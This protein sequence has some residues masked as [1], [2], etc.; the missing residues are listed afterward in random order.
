MIYLWD[1][2]HVDRDYEFCI[3]LQDYHKLKPVARK[4]GTI[5]FIKKKCGL[6]FWLRRNR[7]RKGYFLGVL[8]FCMVIYI[9]SL[10]IWDIN[11]LGGH[12]YTPEAMVKF[13]KNNQIYAGLQK[14]QIDCQD[15]E[16]LIRGTFKDIG[17]V[18]AEIKGTRLIIKITETN[19]P[20][21]AVTATE[22]CHI[23][24]AKDCIISEIITRT[25]TPL[26]KEGSV[27]KKGDILVSG[28][29]DIVGDNAEVVEK[30]AVIA[31]ADIIGKTFYNYEDSFS[32]NYIEKQYTGEEKTGYNLSVFLKKFNLYKPRIPYT[33]YDIIVNESMLHLNDNFFLPVS[34]AV[35]RYVEYEEVKKKYTELEAKSIAEAKLKRFLDK[36]I[37]NDVLIIENNVKIAIK[38]NYCVVS[39]KIVVMESVKDYKAI[40]DSEWRNIDTDESDGN[41][42]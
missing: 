8:L 40:D 27:V 4:T 15:I 31:D 13:L 19:M 10:F 41:D 29:V 17:W 18:S 20:A 16:E 24:A 39:G 38:N 36:L 6:P 25:G 12:S 14:K 21:P 1:L 3:M 42:N 28:I 9:L 11:I 23:I 33:K 37:E 22:N 32:L 2:R 26:V 35:N 34:Y 30:K 7:K 5:P